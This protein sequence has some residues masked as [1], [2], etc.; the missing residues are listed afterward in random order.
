MKKSLTYLTIPIF[1]YLFFLSQNSLM[2][3]F[4]LFIFI[5]LIFSFDAEKK[6]LLFKSL[7]VFICGFLYFAFN[8]SWFSRFYSWA[9]PV[10][11]VAAS[12]F[13][14]VIPYYIFSLTWCSK[15]K[16]PAHVLLLASLWTLFEYLMQYFPISFPYNSIALFLYRD[17]ILIQLADLTGQYG[18][19]FLIILVNGLIYLGALKF[20][21][22][23]KKQAFR[24]FL[25]V[26][27]IFVV[28]IVY[29]MLSVLFFDFDKELNIDLAQ[30]N[31]LSVEKMQLN[32]DSY[33]T[34]VNKFI[35]QRK[36]ESDLIIF[37]ETLFY[38]DIA[39]P[40]NHLNEYL[41]FM[42][43]EQNITICGGF[44]EESPDSPYYLYNSVFSMTPENQITVSRKKILA[45][46]GE[47]YPLG[48][49]FPSLKK[50]LEEKQGSLFFN[51]GREISHHNFPDS[52]GNEWSFK[53]LI[54]YESA[55]GSLLKGSKI[56]DLDFFVNISSDL[57]T[58]SYKALIQN[59]I[60]SKFRAIEYR[61]PIVRVSNGGLSGYISS[62]G[63]AWLPLP[64]FSEG[65]AHIRLV[66]LNHPLVYKQTLY[67]FWGDI[68]VT[69]SAIYVISFLIFS[70]KKKRQESQSF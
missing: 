59:A 28:W 44:I 38:S 60:F 63:K 53:T 50:N 46:F 41:R 29:G 36:P 6:H 25:S 64:A 31:L 43:Q 24:L 8:F 12:L 42:A 56:S 9:V 54:C 35:N 15:H 2:S 10:F 67:S 23:Q 22:K 20:F 5:P 66:K 62:T 13:H 33:K 58:G 7:L 55:Y 19:T 26:G 48:F 30:S 61:M 69:I 51:R 70:F 4:S 27:I 68:I 17:M 21:N 16:T 52:E 11:S 65:N 57:W 39:N 3:Y 40:D 1:F 47:Y 32:E 14:F 45:P 34:L 18:I 49:L 37:P